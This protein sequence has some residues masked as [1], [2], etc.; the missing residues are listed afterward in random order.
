MKEK[1][2]RNSKTAMWAE[3]QKYY[4]VAISRYYYSIL[5]KIILFSKA[6][7]F[8][9]EPQ[10]GEDSHNITLDNFIGNIS[11]KLRYDQIL[12]IQKIKRLKYERR[13]A[14]YDNEKN[15][16]EVIFNRDFKRSFDEVNTIIDD[17]IKGVES[18]E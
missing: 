18:N 15:Y 2:K 16:N 7:G 8:Y 9:V 1:S 11:D 10:K 12:S 17:L 5:Q 4:D 6:S 3:A 13:Y 14:D